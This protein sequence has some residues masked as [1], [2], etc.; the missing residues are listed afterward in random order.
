MPADPALSRA[1]AEAH[2]RRALTARL[3]LDQSLADLRRAVELWPGEARFWYHLGLTLHRADQ[4][5]E[6]RT[7][8]A[9]AASLATNPVE[10][11]FLTDRIATH[12]APG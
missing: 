7:A 8:Y 9:L 10:R 2:F 4:V 5:A 3:P 12:R 11:A 6:A 1:L